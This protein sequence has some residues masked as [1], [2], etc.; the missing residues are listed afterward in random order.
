MRNTFVPTVISFDTTYVTN[1]YIMLFTPFIGV[2]NRFHSRLIGYA[3]LVSITGLYRILLALRLHPTTPSIIIRFSYNHCQLRVT[4][5]LAIT[6]HV[7]TTVKTDKI[8]KSHGEERFFNQGY[9]IF[10][11]KM[12]CSA[13]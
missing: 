5:S 2:N 3:I 4:I 7:T 9:I 10:S 8:K 13:P 11:R 12:M 6:F 1:K